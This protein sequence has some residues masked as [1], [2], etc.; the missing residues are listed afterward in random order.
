M[1]VADNHDGALLLLCFWSNLNLEYCLFHGEFEVRT[2]SHNR[3]NP[4]V[5]AGLGMK[6]VGRL[7]T[8]TIFFSAQE[9][10]RKSLVLRLLHKYLYLQFFV[11]SKRKLDPS[12][13]FLQESNGKLTC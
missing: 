1:V 12:K 9:V 8:S 4:H 11:V 5:T 7:L 2:T 13:I 10:G 6:P 3:V